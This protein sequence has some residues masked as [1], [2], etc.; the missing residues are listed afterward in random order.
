M[1]APII[2]VGILTRKAITFTFNQE[3]IMVEDGTFLK[4]EQRAIWI[5]GKIVF[6]GKMYNRLFFKPTSQDATF[7]LHAVTIGVDFHWQQQ[8]DQRFQGALKIIPAEEGLVAINL[9]DVEQYLTCVI[10]SEMNARAPKEFLKTHAVISRSWLLAQIEKRHKQTAHPQSYFRDNEKLIRW[11]DR[12]DHTLFDVCAD[13][14]CQRYQGMTRTAGNPVI[15]AVIKETKGEILTYEEEICDTRFSKCCGGITEEFEHCWEPVHHPYL[16]GVADCPSNTKHIPDLSQEAE[17]EK[18]IRSCPPAFCQTNDTHLLSLILNQYDQSTSFYRWE[19]S[20]PQEELS[21]LVYRKSGI[22]FG[23]IIALIPL[24]R[25]KSGRIEELKIVGSE[26]S[27]IIGKELEIRRILSESHLYS[28]A[29]VVE[30]FFEEDDPQIPARF[31][32]KGAGWG[33]GVGLCQIGAAVMSTQGYN[34]RQI[35]THYFPGANLDKH[36]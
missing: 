35:L 31:V 24:K 20:Y 6:K 36:Y 34:Y 23:K 21:E 2:H 28:S 5:N 13:D 8:E 14:H 22:P 10:A 11:Y 19:V 12:K 16:S 7:N 9:I 33:H 3:Y 32:L 4:G 18:W 1:Q 26:H 17:A 15:Q 25:G 29:F 30:R 27:Y